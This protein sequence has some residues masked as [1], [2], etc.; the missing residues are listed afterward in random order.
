MYFLIDMVIITEFFEDEDEKRHSLSFEAFH[1]ALLISLYQDEP[2]F[3]M[4]YMTI[5]LIMDVDCL[6]SK[7]R[8][9]Y[10]NLAS[11][12]RIVYLIQK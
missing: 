10:N 3:Q 1:G 2:E 12:Y 9:E 11:Q 6:I 7:W 8:R 5:K 4:A